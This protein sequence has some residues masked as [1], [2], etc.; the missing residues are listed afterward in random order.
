MLPSLGFTALLAIVFFIAEQYG[1]AIWLHPYWKYMLI[2][3]LS[4]SFLIH[5]LMDIGFQN[6]REKFVEFYMGSIVARLVLCIV[7][8]GVFLWWGVSAVKLFILDFLALYIFYT[9]FEIYILNR[10]LRRDL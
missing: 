2:F 7:F 9:A 1:A 4:I 3:F 6:N 8:V 5:R 10:N